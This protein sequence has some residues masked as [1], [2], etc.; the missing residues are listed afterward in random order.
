MVQMMSDVFLCSLVQ[1]TD[2][3]LLFRIPLSDYRF[4]VGNVPAS[5][6]F[7]NH[8]YQGDGDMESGIEAEA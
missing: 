8:D 5:D 1:I 3:C 6:N 2:T 7:G 4:T